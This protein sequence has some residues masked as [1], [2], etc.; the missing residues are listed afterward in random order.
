MLPEV[1]DVDI[2]INGRDLK[3]DTMRAQGAGGQ[4]VNKTESA[5]RITHLPSGIVVFVQEERSQ[6][7]NKAKAM[8]MLRA[9]LY[10][11]E[12]SK[13]DA[14]RAADRRGQIGSGDRSERIRTYNFPQGRVTD[15]RINLTLY[16]LPQVIE[17]EALDEVID[18]LVTEH[19][20]ALLAAEGADVRVIRGLKAGAVDRRGAARMMAQ[21]SARPAS[22]T[23][24]L[25]ARILVAH[26]L[27]STAP[28]VMA[29][30]DRELEPREIERSRALRRAAA[31]ARA[32]R[33]H[34]RPQE[35]WSLPLRSR[36]R[37]AGAASGN[38]DHRRSGARL[39]RCAAICA[40]SACACSIIGTGSGALLLAL[41]HELPN[42]S[43][44]GTDTTLARWLARAP[45][46]KV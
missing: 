16:K 43:G 14:E 15:H 10:D 13:L 37:R 30:G 38:R 31:R 25:D 29:Q 35:F 45:M 12:R 27:G 11:A 5:I 28:Q 44:I 1:E 6:H 20:A 9:K 21:A 34:P 3:I 7:K 23:P 2:D 42:A 19:Q 8:A 39:R 22:K 41:L 40:R 36:R 4:H 33:A 17:G 18:A 46:R 32:G 26:A 24:E